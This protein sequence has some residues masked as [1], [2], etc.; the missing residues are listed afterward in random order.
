MH[1]P[2]SRRVLHLLGRS[3][4]GIRRHVRYLAANPPEGFVTAGVMG[5]RSVHHY[6]HDLDFKV[7][8]GRRPWRSLEPDVIHAHGLTAGLRAIRSTMMLPGRPPVVVTVHT[9]AQQTLRATM[10]GANLPFIQGAMWTLGRTLISRADAVIAVSE[11]V[12]AN[13]GATDTVAPAIDLANG[14][15]IPRADVRRELEVPEDTIVVLAVGRLHPDKALHLFIEAVQGTGAVGWIAGEGPD[16]PRLEELAAGTGV[17]LLGQ[18]EDVPSLLEA[19]DIFALPTAGESYGLAAIE[20]MAAGL[21][22]VA[23]RTGAIPE[24]V[25][26]A[27]LLVQP[28]DSA[29]FVEAVHRLIEDR[30]LRRNLGL[31]AKSRELPSAKDLAAEIGRIYER[32]IAGRTPRGRRF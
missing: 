24:I 8:D 29:G 14:L 19:A 9:S 26:D 4:G 20:A 30:E 22:V 11:E 2:G 1:A 23:T 10:P 18:R 17:R 31:A 12:S 27:G 15:T 7:W 21:P 5:P 13:F 6:F 16:W 28:G 32:V 25:A 3:S